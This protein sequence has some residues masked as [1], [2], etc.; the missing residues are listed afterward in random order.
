VL[1]LR[2]RNPVDGTILPTKPAATAQG[3]P[4][5]DKAAVE[6]SAALLP[7]V[8]A[9]LRRISDAKITTRPSDNPPPQPPVI[10]PMAS[11]WCSCSRRP[12]TKP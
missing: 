11:H 10:R 9:E 12:A 6:L 1:S 3:L 8:R 2:V 7:V 4:N 5:I